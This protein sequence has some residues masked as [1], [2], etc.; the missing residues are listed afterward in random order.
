MLS[1]IAQISTL[2]HEIDVSYK[3]AEIFSILRIRKI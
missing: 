2:L 3:N 1:H